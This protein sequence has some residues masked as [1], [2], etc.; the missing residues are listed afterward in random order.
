M[1]DPRKKFTPWLVLLIV[2][3]GPLQ[4]GGANILRTTE[5]AF[6]PLIPEYP[7]LSN[8]IIIYQLLIGTSI[9]VWVYTAWVL[10]RRESGT[11][12]K[13]QTGY[14]VGAAL[15]ILG[16]FSIVLLGGLPPDMT[17]AMFKEILPSGAVAL[18]A[19]IAWSLYLTRSSRVREIYA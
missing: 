18:V 8:A 6:R 4:L 2:L 17:S 14:L 13:A 10:F 16:A 12:Y 3:I 1:Q 5:Q 9:A 15:R 19:V 7:S 11:L